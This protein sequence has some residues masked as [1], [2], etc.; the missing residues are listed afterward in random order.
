MTNE[1]KESIEKIAN[2]LMFYENIIDTSSDVRKIQDAKNHIDELIEKICS[3]D[4]QLMF[5]VDN[6]IAQIKGESQ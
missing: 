6:Y 5:D 2:Y 1:R 4:Y 3:I